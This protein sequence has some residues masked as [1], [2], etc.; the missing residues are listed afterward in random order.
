MSKSKEKVFKYLYDKC[1]EQK[2]L[3]KKDSI[4]LSTKE[5]AEGL[6]MQRTNVSSIL[7][8]LCK[9]G[10]VF[11]IKGK[12]IIYTVI[13]SNKE[14]DNLSKANENIVSSSVSLDTVIGVNGSLKK[15]VQQAKA[16]ILYPPNGLHTLLLGP[17]GVGKTM[18]AELMYRFAIEK[19][20]I[21]HDA[22]FV[23]FNCA[24]Y[25][26]NQQL[27]M[28]HLFGSKK[29]AFTGADRDRIGLVDKANGGVLFLD[30]VHRLP[31]EG[32]EMLFM[33]IDKGFYTP[34]G[35]IEK[36]KTS[37]V[38]IICATTENVDSALLTTFTRRIPMT[39]NIPAL[40][41]RT[42]EERFELICNF[43]KIESKRIG[44]EITVSTNTIRSLLLYNCPGNIG[45]LKSDIQLG[46]ANAFLKFVSR[47]EKKMQVYSTDFPNN[48]R[49]GLV[50][51]KQYS[52][53]VDEIIKE[54]TKLK[55]NHK[56]A[57]L[58]KKSEYD[59]LPDNFYEI[60]EKRIKELKNRGVEESDINFIMSFDIKNYFNKYIGK[61]EQEINKDELSKI[62]DN[63]IICIIEDFLKTASKKLMRNFPTKVFYGLCLHVSSS[64]ERIL[65]GKKIINHNL[66]EIIQKHGE[67]Y[68]LGLILANKLEEEFNIKIPADEVGF[69]SMFL[70][71]EDIED[72]CM[73]N[74]PIIVV[75]MHGRSTASSMA[76]VANKLVGANNVY[77]YDMNLDKKPKVAYNELKNLIIANH[78][79]EGVILLVDMG[80]LGMF[81][82]LISEETGIEIR[83]ISMV[84]TLLVIEC[85]RKALT[86]NDI[87]QIWEEA[88]QSV[89]F[90][91]SYSNSLTQNYIPSKDNIIITTCITGEGSAIKLKNMIEEKINL[92]EKD[93]QVIA[94]SANDKKEMYNTINTLSK[95][96]KIIAVAGSVNPNIYDI[97]F[98]PIS[99]LFMD[100]NY[101]RLKNIVSRVTPL[102][103]F[104]RDIFD[105]L[106]NEIKEISISEFK[107]MCINLIDSI[108]N[109]ITRDLDLY[110]ISGFILHLACAIVR[111][112][113]K[114]KTSEC[115]RKNQIIETFSKEY[116]ELKE[117]LSTIENFYSIKF[118]D[119][120]LSYML[121]IILS[122]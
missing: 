53:K 29:G 38:L 99:E 109:N 23:S 37:K 63:K 36:K 58:Q 121:M 52:Y 12:P 56:G 57:K 35:D 96:K 18:F 94:I 64:I 30:E 61:F 92:S 66:N 27:L 50:L 13:L 54:D 45:Q 117:A 10:K 84:S 69:L 59:L 110:K 9:E 78:Q 119:D 31:P 75:A 115:S 80:S 32:Q 91:N 16:A 76:E 60:I 41:D 33:L 77:A 114:E 93:I 19:G 3:E 24:D 22:P 89:S 100:S 95:K 47:G 8:K 7:N 81:G 11:K 46:C 72:G 15:S 73:N 4:G 43:F 68:G 87:D 111:L 25:A 105:N 28:A 34:L 49:Q 17:T 118:S 67:E 6:S 20:V 88:K 65:Q 70:C 116:I 97:P 85:A 21:S 90:L 82:E 62:V 51:Y 42:L 104:Y 112:I 122:I 86:N 14:N 1:Q 39:I 103:D 120:E 101:T 26:N 108:R 83:V 113:N 44:R 74:K 79:N 106:E 102:Q 71:V 48:V 5:I 107:P 55:F 2:S 40:K 98:I